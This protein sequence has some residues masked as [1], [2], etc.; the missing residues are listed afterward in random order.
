MLDKPEK[1]V[2]RTTAPS[3]ST[4]FE[5]LAYCLNVASLSLLYRYSRDSELA[6]LVPLH[7]HGKFIHYS[8]RVHD[9]QLELGILCLESAFI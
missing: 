9:A 7:S 1:Q 4:P 5:P 2:C 6:Q 3:L 8:D